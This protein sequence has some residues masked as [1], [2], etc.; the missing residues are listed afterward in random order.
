MKV[1]FMGTPHFAVPTLHQIFKSDRHEI[2][3][4]VTNID[5]PKGRGR[6]LQP[7][8]V[9][10]SALELGLKV[11][12]AR[13][14][15]DPDLLDRIRGIRPDVFVVVAFRILP[16]ELLSIPG[17]G[18]LN[19]HAS[20]LPKYRGAAPI[21]WALINGDKKTG[22]TIM[23]IDSGID[24]GN[25]LLQEETEIF[26][27]ENAGKLSE[28]LS[29]IGA[30]LMIP[31]L[32]GVE[33]NT[34]KPI[35]QDTSLSSRAPKITP[36]IMKIDWSEP[37]GGIVNLIRGLSPDSAPFTSVKGKKLKIFSAGTFED[38]KEDYLPG[39]IIKADAKEGFLIMAGRGAVEL[40][41]VQREGKKVMSAGDYLRGNVTKE[42]DRL[43]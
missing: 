20:L 39:T 25:I 21:Q 7:S 2:A 12:Q 18:A 14:M 35:K 27:E 1:I 42:G 13:S 9:K 34:I 40:F 3:A 24:T 15:K 11:I 32:D 23:Q 33:N 17:Y 5:K 38:V 6:K 41:T 30:R 22:V 10:T 43:Q 26:P 4:V 31:A 19:L 16:D 28:R 36:D 29:E 37:A 8:P